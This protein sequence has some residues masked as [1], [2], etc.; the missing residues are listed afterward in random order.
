MRDVLALVAS[1]LTVVTNVKPALAVRADEVAEK[2]PRL[3]REARASLV[4]VVTA[5]AS[6]AEFSFRVRIERGS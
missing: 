3:G 4:A 5:D 2:S 6:R 1:N